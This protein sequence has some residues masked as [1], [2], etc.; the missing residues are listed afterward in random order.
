[1]L[2]TFA[3]HRGRS[4]P[5][6]P[7]PAL[8]NSVT[9][10][11]HSRCALIYSRPLFASSPGVASSSFP[12]CRC[13]RPNT[14]CEPGSPAD[15]SISSLT[16]GQ[17]RSLWQAAARAEAACRS[18]AAFG[19]TPAC[20]NTSSTSLPAAIRRSRISRHRRLERC[21]AVLPAPSCGAACPPRRIEEMGPGG[22]NPLSLPSLIK[23]RLRLG[24]AHRIREPQPGLRHPVVH[25]VENAPEEIDQR[26]VSHNR[27]SYRPSPGATREPIGIGSRPRACPLPELCR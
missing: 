15:L 4:R 14:W 9:L 23:G 17:L 27:H 1:M 20:W 13:C 10:D 25:C 5:H 2:S 8:A 19:H 3:G 22:R 18:S 11:N 12:S 7:R 26:P 6:I 16:L 21:A 24:A